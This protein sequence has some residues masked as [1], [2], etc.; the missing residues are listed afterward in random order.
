MCTINGRCR[1][2]T[3]PRHARSARQEIKQQNQRQDDAGHRTEN[4]GAE[5]GKHAGLRE[6]V[7][8][9]GGR[10]RCKLRRIHWLAEQADLAAAD[11]ALG[12]FAD[13]GFEIVED[14]DHLAGERRDAEI[15][16]Q[17]REQQKQA[18]HQQNEDQ[19]RQP[20][21]GAGPVDRRRS[22]VS[23][24]CGKHERRQYPLYF[25]KNERSRDQNE[26]RGLGGNPVDMLVIAGAKSKGLTL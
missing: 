22:D 13:D 5:G 23:Q 6:P 19:P 25:I 10:G 11:H 4:G 9:S 15:A 18:K 3:S 2:G 16:D 26:Y 8:Q 14:A 7:A 17:H 24:Q 20:A 1:G 12:Q 21:A